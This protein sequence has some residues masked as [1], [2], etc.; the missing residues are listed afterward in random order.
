MAGLGQQ[1]STC[2]ELGSGKIF[3]GCCECR[4]NAWFKVLQIW[5]FLRF[6]IAQNA[7]SIT[8]LR[9]TLAA[10]TGEERREKRA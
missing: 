1:F 6:V 10:R 9:D 7:M 8:A 2:S 5:L 3:C 4:L